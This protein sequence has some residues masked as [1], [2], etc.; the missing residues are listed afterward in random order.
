V[1]DISVFLLVRALW[2]RADQDFGRSAVARGGAS[3]RF[4][5]GRRFAPPSGRGGTRGRF[6]PLPWEIRVP[7][8]GDSK[9]PVGDS[10]PSRGRFAP[11]VG[12]SG[13]SHGS[14]PPAG[15]SEPSRGSPAEGNRWESRK[16]QQI[17]HKPLEIAHEPWEIAGKPWEPAPKLRSPDTE[18]PKVAQSDP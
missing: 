5:A 1:Q 10:G 6:G 9:S 18:F 16:T 15:D 14:G 11:P 17:A 12:D 4:G 7:P 2:S 3:R 13:L 8:G